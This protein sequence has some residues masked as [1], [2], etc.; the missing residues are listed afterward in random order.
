MSKAKTILQRHRAL[1]IYTDFYIQ[2]EK[3]GKKQLFMMGG[4]FTVWIQNTISV[5]GG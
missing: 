1:S 2:I 4:N 3:F 5:L